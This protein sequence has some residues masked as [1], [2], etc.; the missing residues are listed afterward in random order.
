MGA[1][2]GTKQLNYRSILFNMKD[3][4]N[5]DLRRKVLLGQ[6]KPEKLVTMTSE[7]MASSQRQFENEQIRKKSLC[8]EMKKAEQEHKLVDPMEY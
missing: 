7:E 8:K 2:N 6:I 3:P 4:K 5:P 1:F